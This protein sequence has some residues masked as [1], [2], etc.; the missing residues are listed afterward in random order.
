MNDLLLGGIACD[1]VIKV[2]DDVNADAAGEVVLGSRESGG[3]KAR[4]ENKD[5]LHLL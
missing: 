5:C 2:G 4:E 1:E 3:Q